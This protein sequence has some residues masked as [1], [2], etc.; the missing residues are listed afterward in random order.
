V[1]VA[2]GQQ[3]DRPAVRHAGDADARIAGRVELHLGAVGQP[4]DQLADVGDLAV[5]RVQPDLTAG[6]AEA[7]RRPGE[8]RVAVPGEGFGLTAYV[9]LA[10]AEAV[11]DEHRGSASAAARGE[12]RGVQAYA[13]G[14]G[15]HRVGAVHGRITGRRRR[16]DRHSPCHQNRERR[17]PGQPLPAPRPSKIHP[18]ILGGRCADS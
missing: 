2:G 5:L 6:V 1:V 16:T 3:R 13:A 11:A 8:H 10:A 17:R 14:A 12:V 18:L 7:A 9:V 15:E 4:V